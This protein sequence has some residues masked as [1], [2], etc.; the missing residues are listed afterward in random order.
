MPFQ[1]YSINHTDL[2]CLSCVVGIGD[3]NDQWND[4][5]R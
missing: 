5:L 1:I 3:K 2:S 4:K